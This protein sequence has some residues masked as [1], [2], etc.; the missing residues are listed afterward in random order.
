MPCPNLAIS[1][2]SEIHRPL[3]FWHI[4]Q[5]L[6]TEVS[7]EKIMNDEYPWNCRGKILLFCLPTFWPIFGA[8]VKMWR[9]LRPQGMKCFYCPGKTIISVRFANIGQKVERQNNEIFPHALSTDFPLWWGQI[10][11]LVR[12]SVNYH[13]TI[14]VNI[15]FF[16]NHA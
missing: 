1:P 4:Q 6:V 14:G 11:A 8:L 13:K 12:Y 5:Y 16:T 9:F 2:Y 15:P 7:G 3:W 10:M